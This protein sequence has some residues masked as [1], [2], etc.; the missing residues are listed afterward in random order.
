MSKED[1]SKA[2]ALLF[3]VAGIVAL[4]FAWRGFIAEQ[5]ALSGGGAGSS[6][7]PSLVGPIVGSIVALFCFAVAVI[8]RTI[9]R[10]KA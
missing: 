5:I 4:L 8:V 6:W 1:P 2:Y 9:A 3:V 7:E 10:A